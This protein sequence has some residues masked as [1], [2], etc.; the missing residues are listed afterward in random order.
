MAASM[1]YVI[2]MM[3]AIAFALIAIL[4][5]SSPLATW[6]VSDMTFESPEDGANMHELISMTA[7]FAALILG[8]IAGWVVSSRYLD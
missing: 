3:G 7:N 5:L 8:W 4:F 1:R 6:L 2:S